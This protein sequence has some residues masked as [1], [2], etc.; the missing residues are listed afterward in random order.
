[1]PLPRFLAK[2]L[3]LLSMT[4]GVGVPSAVLCIADDH[5]GYEAAAGEGHCNDDD[6]PA[7]VAE[8]DDGERDCVDVPSTAI[9]ADRPVPDAGPQVPMPLPAVVI[10]LLPEP[11]A[12]AWRTSVGEGGGLPS[13]HLVPLRSFVLLT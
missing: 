6:S 3:A 7:E 13:P 5:L 10:A 12:P 11:R 2:L 8:V 4:A 9:E 1:M